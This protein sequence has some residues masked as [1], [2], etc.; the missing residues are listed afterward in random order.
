MQAL[1]VGFML[2]AGEVHIWQGTAAA[3]TPYADWALLSGQEHARWRRLP[4]VKAASYAASHAAVRR[5][6]G[7]YLHT[8][9]VSLRLGRA[10]CLVCGRSE[11]GR[12]VVHTDGDPLWFSLSRSGPDWIVALSRSMLGVD[13]EVGRTVDIEAMESLVLSDNERRV[14]S[15]HDKADRPGMFFR[16]WTRKEA[17]LKAAGIGLFSDLTNVDVQPHD[18]G[19]VIV[20]C[21]S[22]NGSRR[23]RVRSLDAG[24]G[25]YAAVASPADIEIDVWHRDWPSSCVPADLQK[26]SG[27]RT[28]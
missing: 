4:A 20:E 2:T 8:A 25:R 12:P 16:C 27:W 5:I 9:P 3:H 18:E 19:E 11:A 26:I 10:S 6:L 24:A 23:W 13:I 1:T 28:P 7:R 21:K 17:V 14:I 22:R 15:S